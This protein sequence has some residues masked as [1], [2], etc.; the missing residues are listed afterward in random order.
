M[1]QEKNTETEGSEEV[2]IP[3]KPIELVGSEKGLYQ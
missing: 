3:T 1:N 2:K